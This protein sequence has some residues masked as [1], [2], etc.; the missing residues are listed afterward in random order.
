MGFYED[1]AEAL[2]RE[3]I[4]SRVNDDI[5]FVPIAPELEVQFH[6]I[7]APGMAPS[8]AAA[9]VFLA[10]PDDDLEDG[11]D[12]DHAFEPHRGKAKSKK[13]GHGPNVKARKE[14]GHADKKGK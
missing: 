9:N 8:L 10:S 1:L 5:L 2:D 14:K 11:L 3:G 13:S 4:E 6:E 12:L 7:D